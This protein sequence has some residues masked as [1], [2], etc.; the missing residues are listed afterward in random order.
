MQEASELAIV[1][2]D[3]SM[4]TAVLCAT[5]H[6]E[7]TLSPEATTAIANALGRIA[8]R[9][10][11]YDLGDPDDLTEAAAVVHTVALQLRP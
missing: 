8:E 2:S 11:T 9:M 10:Q 5:A 7:G 3:L 1:V 4:V 6:R